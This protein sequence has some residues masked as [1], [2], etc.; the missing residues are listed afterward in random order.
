MRGTIILHFDFRGKKKKGVIKLRAFRNAG[1]AKWIARNWSL[2]I[3]RLW[4]I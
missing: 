1:P 4:V 3:T 2:R